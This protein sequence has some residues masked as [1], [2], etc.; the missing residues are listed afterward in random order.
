M[1]TAITT[2]LRQHAQLLV[3]LTH[4][5]NEKQIYTNPPSGAWSIIQNCDH[6]MSVEFGIYRLV[7][8][9]GSTPES[10]RESKLQYILDNAAN[11]SV[12]VK[13]P[14]PL[15]PK[16]KTDTIEKF[17]EKYI[18]LRSKIITAV[19]DKDLSRV[20]QFPHFV[21]GELTFEEWLVFLMEHSDR[22]KA[23]IEEVIEELSA[24]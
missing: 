8:S 12:K 4:T 2:K 21:F 6:L 18:S 17:R 10:N 1:N 7:E 15:T 16:G 3:E 14:P 20:A 19:A 9:E 5:Y 23:Q 22:H 24:V 11:R 13:A